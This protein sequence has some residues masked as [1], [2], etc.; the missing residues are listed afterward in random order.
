[1]TIRFGKYRIGFF[2]MLL[3]PLLGVIAM[4]LLLG[5]FIKGRYVPE[6][7]LGYFFLNGMLLYK[8]FASPLNSGMNSIDSFKAFLVYP[9]VKPLDNLL[10][11]FLY[12]LCTQFFSFTLFCVVASLFGWGFSLDNLHVVLECFLLTWLIGCGLGLI[13]GVVCAHYNDAEKIIKVILKPL[14]FVSCVLHPLSKVPSEFQYFLLFNPLCHTIEMSRNALF[15]HYSIIG[16]NFFYPSVFAIIVL[17]LGLT[18]FQGNRN[19]LS[20]S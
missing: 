5:P 13:L 6:I 12:D 14:S 17:A 15:P 7:P 18:L 11:S 4:G 9:R 8:L 3:E 16:P 10:A 1:M 2:W 20:Q 19:F